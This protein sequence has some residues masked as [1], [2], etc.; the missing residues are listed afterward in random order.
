MF[1]GRHLRFLE[2]LYRTTAQR[3]RSKSLCLYYIT[4]YI[5]ECMLV[6]YVHGILA[7][8]AFR[9]SMHRDK[10]TKQFS[11]SNERRRSRFHGS[12]WFCLEKARHGNSRDTPRSLL[13]GCAPG[14]PAGQAPSITESR[15]VD[16][17]AHT[18]KPLRIYR[19]R[20]C[21]SRVKIKS[22]GGDCCFHRV[23][24]SLASV[25]WM[26]EGTESIQF[27]SIRSNRETGRNEYRD[28][29]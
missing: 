12:G 18:P 14:E 6:L 13:L 20:V 8:I 27:H 4:I 1:C 19:H 28:R 2:S 24:A 23:F 10:R 11:C 29:F 7:C 5:P 26:F 17:T 21:C 22:V 15:R 3:N 9:K 25:P 16:S